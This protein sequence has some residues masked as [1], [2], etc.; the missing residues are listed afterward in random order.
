MQDAIGFA[1]AYT[2]AVDGG[3][4]PRGLPVGTGRRSAVTV[5]A[6]ALGLSRSV[7]DRLFA[8]AEAGKLIE[9]GFSTKRVSGAYDAEGNLLRQWIGSVRAPGD[10][11]EVP[12]GHVV[13]GESALLDPDGRT[14]ARWI[15]TREG[16]GE[17]LV[18]GLRAA[19]AAYDG[20]APPV[21]GPAA[22]D[23]DTLTVYPLPDL[24]LGMYAWGR[25]TGA[26]Y[27]TDIAVDLA[28]RS[29]AD[30]VGHSRPSARAVILG[31]GDY[32]HANDAKAATPGSGHSLDVDARWPKVFAAGAML[33]TAIV[34]IVARKHSEVEVVFLPGNHDPDAAMSL[35]VALALFYSKTRHVKVHQEP[36]IAWYLRFGA[37]LIGA[38]H[39]HTM[40]PDRMAMML[41]MD[42]AEDWGQT[43][44]R[45]LM[46]GHVHHETMRECGGVRVESFSSPA[47]RDAWNAAGGYRAGRA[48]SA[49]TYHRERGEVGRHRVNISNDRRA[50]A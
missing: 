1:A 45:H 7:A 34:D 28:T 21:P 24:H 5:A 10:P 11:Y 44:H 42:R 41:A 15:K 29:I 40:K 2:E 13:K 9:R 17:G 4:T 46:F 33:A 27:D 19:F 48:M 23:D 12:A 37:N 20:A 22:S 8:E 36:G 43:K 47:A 38:T 14:L 39:G 30:L 6:E 18:D 3:A 50:A 25:E 26:N 16:A 35:T 32:F 31:L 49:I